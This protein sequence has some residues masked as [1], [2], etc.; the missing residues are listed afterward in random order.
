ML[1]VESQLKHG[2]IFLTSIQNVVNS[3]QRSVY[4]KTHYTPR[5]QGAHLLVAET[6]SKHGDIDLI[7]IQNV[8]IHKHRSVFG[9]P[10][11]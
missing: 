11:V 6:Q 4:E 3:N 8:I 5:K 7:A 9:A 2:D 10:F 1:T